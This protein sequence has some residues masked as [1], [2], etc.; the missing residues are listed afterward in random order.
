[1]LRQNEGLCFACRVFD[2]ALLKE[3]ICDVPVYPFPSPRPVMKRQAENGQ[4]GS[5]QFVGV[6]VHGL[7]PLLTFVIVFDGETGADATL[8]TR[9]LVVF[10]RMS[11]FSGGDAQQLWQLGYRSRFWNDAWCLRC[12]FPRVAWHAGRKVCPEHK[13]QLPEFSP[14]PSGHSSRNKI[15]PPCPSPLRSANG[16]FRPLALAR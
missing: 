5:I 8:H 14:A 16:V 10:R 4:C 13:G 7:Y 15:Q 2:Q 1:M 11:R 3:P 12:F 6:Y 9:R